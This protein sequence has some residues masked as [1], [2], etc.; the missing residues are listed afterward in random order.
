MG[1]GADEGPE[2]E[3][4]VPI[5]GPGWEGALAPRWLAVQPPAGPGDLGRKWVDSVSAVTGVEPRGLLQALRSLTTGASQADLAVLQ[6]P[7][8]AGGGWG[9]GAGW[10]LGGF[11]AAVGQPGLPAL[12]GYQVSSGS[13][14]WS[15][16]H[17]PNR[18]AE[19]AQPG[20]FWRGL[21]RET[22][23]DSHPGSASKA[24]CHPECCPFLSDLSVP[25]VLQAG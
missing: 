7:E 3:G 20:G 24:L 25:T 18:Q 23:L 4:R 2:A 15:F 16:S 19:L 8:G 10:A 12:A 6:R 1:T 22:G 17:Q 5:A 9:G 11:L 14:E 21:R 13:P